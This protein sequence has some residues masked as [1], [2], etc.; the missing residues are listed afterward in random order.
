MLTRLPLR[1]T[2]RCTTTTTCTTCPPHRHAAAYGLTVRGR[3]FLSDCRRACQYRKLMTNSVPVTQ[4]VDCGMNTDKLPLIGCLLR[5]CAY[6]L[7]PFFSRCP[8]CLPTLD[9]YLLLYATLT[10]WRC[11]LPPLPDSRTHTHFATA[12][13]HTTYPLPHAHVAQR[14]MTGG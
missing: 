9:S 13:P 2:A 1:D 3:R 10:H 11:H 12:S 7:P 4:Q 6:R 8:P 14:H 5:P